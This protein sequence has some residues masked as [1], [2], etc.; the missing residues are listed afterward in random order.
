MKIVSHILK[1][2]LS[3]PSCAPGEG[4]GIVVDLLQVILGGS[5]SSVRMHKMAAVVVL[6]AAL[7]LAASPTASAAAVDATSSAIQPLSHRSYIKQ[8]TVGF[9]SSQY[10]NL[11]GSTSIEFTGCTSDN[12]F[13]SKSVTVQLHNYQTALPNEHDES[14]TYTKCFQGG[15]SSGTWNRQAYGLYFTINKINGATYGPML[16]VKTVDF[17]H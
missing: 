14:K 12:G 1:S 17:I 9:T 11:E 2:A 13:D 7:P 5:E 6:A 4:V 3:V 16:S 10:D 15:T 8:A